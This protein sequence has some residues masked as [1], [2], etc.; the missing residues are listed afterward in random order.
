[1]HCTVPKSHK[2]H[3][4]SV[5]Y[6]CGVTDPRWVRDLTLTM[7]VEM[8]FTLSSMRLLPYRLE[9]ESVVR[10]VKHSMRI[11]IT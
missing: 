5:Q 7:R 1:M 10:A 8:A 11:M 4:A 6:N 3:T 2:T 9:G